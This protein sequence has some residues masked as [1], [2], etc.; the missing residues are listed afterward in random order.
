V[1]VVPDQVTN[2]KFDL[3]IWH[4]LIQLYD[5]LLRS[6]K[7][8]IFQLIRAGPPIPVHFVDLFSALNNSLKKLH[9][10]QI[11]D[12]LRKCFHFLMTELL[13]P[14]KRTRSSRLNRMCDA[15]ILDSLLSLHPL[16]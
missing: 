6:L 9:F 7:Q 5:D 10:E 2:K 8:F 15:R 3:L 4:D 11:V 14:C 13:F 12:Y 16:P 1:S